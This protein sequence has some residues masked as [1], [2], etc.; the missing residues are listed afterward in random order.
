M[1]GNN[2]LILCQAE[3]IVALQEYMNKRWPDKPP[4]VVDVKSSDRGHEN[5]FV[6]EFH[7]DDA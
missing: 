6:I 5:I 3:M 2:E 1:K 7:D 4:T